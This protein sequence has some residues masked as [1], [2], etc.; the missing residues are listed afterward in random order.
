MSVIFG[1]Y[2][3]DQPAH[4]QDGL[5]MADGVQA[6]ANGYAPIGQF[7]AA[8][9]G[10]LGAPCVGAGAY[11]AA[12]DV[13]IF[14]ATAGKIR[15]YQAPGFTDIKTGLSSTA[16]IGV[17][18][19]PYND[20]MLMTNGV[21]DI[22]KFD[23]ATPSATSALD[24]SAPTARFMAVVRGFVVA[25]YTDGD[26]LRIAWS[27]N[28]DPA[29]WTAGTGEAG[30]QIL[31]SGGDVTGV[32]GGEY[33]LIFQENRIVRM[34]YTAD[35]AVW[36]FDEIATDVGC[37][38]PWSLATY[39]K[40]TFF[41]SNKGLMA[42]DGVSVSAIGSEKV[43]RTFL[44][45]VDRSY[46]SAISA[47]VDPRNSLYMLSVPSA[48]PANQVLLYNFALQRFTTAPITSQRMF[49]SL[50]LGMTLEDMDA[51]YGD[52]DAVALSLDSA[53]FRGG[54]PLVMLFDGNGMLGTLSGD[55][56]AAT[57]VDGMREWFPGRR[58]RITGVRP[59]TDATTA[60][61]SILGQNSLGD[62]PTET[63]FTA[64]SGGGFYRMRQSWNLSQV[65]LAIPAGAPW[66][67][68]QGYDL[69]AV[70]GAR[71]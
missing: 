52:L 43:D 21:D 36:Q 55:N 71:A 3:P 15:R 19:C 50:A 54:Y 56:M 35:D 64:R 4:L 22:Q 27:D 47:V 65:K 6:I 9:N 14:A 66:S 7:A 5:L 46:L 44:H 28:G 31:P 17:R 38:A 12:G 48:S 34:S 58:A 23:P 25:G 16:E 13:F 10:T 70:A 1:E 63:A 11:R 8:E 30:F 49:P 40:L 37:I 45:M 51:V 67:F 60:T 42:C 68:V 53:L 20:L 32:V 2:K 62:M 59:F 24:A 57:L 26:P 61:V 69:E 29:T 18:F 33:G 41:L 39:G